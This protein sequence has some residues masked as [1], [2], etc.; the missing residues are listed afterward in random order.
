MSRQAIEHGLTG[1]DSGHR[2]NGRSALPFPQH[3]DPADRLV[4]V[5]NREL[6]S[7]VLIRILCLL[8]PVKLPFQTFFLSI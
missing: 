6:F 5:N 3:K 2:E 7:M 4:L 1:H 8:T